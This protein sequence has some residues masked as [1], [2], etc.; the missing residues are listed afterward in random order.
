[1]YRMYGPRPHS[2]RDA[3]YTPSAGIMPQAHGRAGAAMYR[4]YGPRP[5][6]IQDAGYTPSVGMI[7]CLLPMPTA[8]WCNYLQTTPDPGYDSATQIVYLL[9]TMHAHI[10]AGLG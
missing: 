2:L 3:G 6:S 1:M 8:F 5:H 10:H 9:M 7:F 4:M